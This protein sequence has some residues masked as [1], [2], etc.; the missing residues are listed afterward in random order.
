MRFSG[1]SLILFYQNLYLQL[2]FSQNRNGF[3]TSHGRPQCDRRCAQTQEKSDG[4]RG[5]FMAADVESNRPDQTDETSV[6]D[7]H[8]QSDGDE[9]VEVIDD[10]Y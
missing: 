1:F 4:L 10:D 5:S 8:A 6:E 3:L 7:A 9:E 2:N